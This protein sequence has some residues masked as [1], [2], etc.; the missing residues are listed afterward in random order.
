[1]FIDI[2]ND[3]FPDTRCRSAR[4][5]LFIKSDKGVEELLG[6]E[7]IERTFGGIRNIDDL[8]TRELKDEVRGTALSWA[9]SDGSCFQV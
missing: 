3:V 1:M 2:L 9:S 5:D 8:L 6:G 4:Y 7:I